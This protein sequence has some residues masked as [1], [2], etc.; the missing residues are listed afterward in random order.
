MLDTVHEAHFY[1]FNNDESLQNQSLSTPNGIW[2]L[3]LPWSYKICGI[4]DQQ[5]Q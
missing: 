3:G 4:L 5:K 1:V 2:L